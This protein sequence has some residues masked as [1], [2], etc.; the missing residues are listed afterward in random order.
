MFIRSV[1]FAQALHHVAITVAPS[2]HRMLTDPHQQW[3]GMVV[4]EE[5]A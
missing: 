2:S 1:R 3:R 5:W 4:P